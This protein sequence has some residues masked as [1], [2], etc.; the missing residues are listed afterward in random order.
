MKM[1]EA[2]AH[3]MGNGAHQ[4]FTSRSDIEGKIQELTRSIS[5]VYKYELLTTNQYLKQME[6]VL[7]IFNEISETL[8]HQ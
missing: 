6:L 7:E 2:C 4:M 5:E 8:V 3:E 1:V